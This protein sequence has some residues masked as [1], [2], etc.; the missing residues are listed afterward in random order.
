VRRSE[1]AGERVKDAFRQWAEGYRGDHAPCRRV[2]AG[3][4][5]TS[6]A[7]GKAQAAQE[8]RPEGRGASQARA[9][10]GVGQA[11]ECR[12]EQ[13]APDANSPSETGDWYEVLQISRHA[14]QETIHRVYRI[15]A[16][17]FHPDNPKTGSTERF[18]LMR[19]AYHVLSDPARRAE[20][21]ATY[22]IART[23]PLPV[24]QLREFVDGVEG[25]RNRRLGILSLLYNSRR[26][27]DARPGIS[28]LELE[29]RMSIPREYLTFTL[30]YL[31][32]KGYVSCE[33]S[34][35][36]AVTPAG[37]DYVESHSSTNTAIRDLLD[38]GSS[39]QTAASA[40]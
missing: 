2:A 22:D 9:D 12:E 20:Y 17:R 6:D 10:T 14:D 33:D 30:W 27:N 8:P 28:V 23:E 1:S 3:E 15:M 13:R 37:V 36:Y 29:Q 4:P 35:D 24:F 5:G 18:L 34:S 32:L 7:A 11:G 26:R 39:G 21:D 38:A 19:R 40:C 16:A 25:E 31:R